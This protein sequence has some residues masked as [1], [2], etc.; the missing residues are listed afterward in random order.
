MGDE[1]NIKIVDRGFKTHNDVYIYTLRPDRKIDF[2][3]SDKV[4]TVEDGAEAQPSFQMTPQMLQAFANTLAKMGVNPA[5]EYIEGKLE[6]T[7]K[8][9]EDMRSLVFKDNK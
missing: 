4:V 5:K 8:H 1:Y 3:Y 6:A 7:E 9:L 2:Y